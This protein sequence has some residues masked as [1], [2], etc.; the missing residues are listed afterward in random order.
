MTFTTRGSPPVTST[1]TS[2]FFPMMRGALAY[3]FVSL[4]EK[5]LAALLG[6]SG[7]F[8]FA[9]LVSAQISLA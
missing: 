6:C 4:T 2:M 5:I 8:H 3:N 9:F 1:P 7:F